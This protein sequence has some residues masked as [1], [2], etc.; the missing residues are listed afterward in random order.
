MFKKMLKGILAVGAALAIAIPAHAEVSGIMWTNATIDQDGTSDVSFWASVGNTLKGEKTTANVT[1]YGGNDGTG[2]TNKVAV[3]TYG[4]DWMF[5]DMLSLHVG[6]RI[7]STN[8]AD[9]GINPSYKLSNFGMYAGAGAH[10]FLE[11]VVDVTIKLNDSMSILTG[12]LTGAEMIPY[13]YVSG[14][15]GD[16]KYYVGARM[17][18]DEMGMVLAGKYSLGDMGSVTLD[19]RM[20]GTFNY[21]GIA[22]N[23]FQAG[24]GSIGVCIHTNSTSTTMNE[25]FYKIPIE[26]GA[27]FTIDYASKTASSVTTSEMGISLEKYF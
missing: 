2:N 5:S 17:N 19:Y 7:Q 8:Y 12:M 3:W 20:K 10:I 26:P 1:L 24:P 18:K 22:L 14:N 6:N 13:I 23:D 11:D 27:N 15:A 9:S 25:L 21:T 4:V 16:I